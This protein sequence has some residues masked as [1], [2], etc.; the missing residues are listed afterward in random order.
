M[1]YEQATRILEAANYNVVAAI[2]MAQAGIGYDDAMKILERSN[3]I[4]TRAIELA[5]RLKESG[6]IAGVQY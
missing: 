6:E 1:T 4:P 5:K 2:V 3:W